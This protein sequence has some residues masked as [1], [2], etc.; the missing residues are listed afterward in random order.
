[1]CIC[2][3]PWAAAR[4]SN[5]N[6]EEGGSAGKGKRILNLTGVK[7]KLDLSMIH[8]GPTEAAVTEETVLVPEVASVPDA[9]PIATPVVNIPAL[10]ADFQAGDFGL[11][12]IEFS[13]QA[14][15]IDNWP[16]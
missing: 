1:M 4:S 3:A 10:L 8:V 13:P 7:R 12:C 16:L 2:L 6:V 5:G 9:D 15:T 14:C 11:G